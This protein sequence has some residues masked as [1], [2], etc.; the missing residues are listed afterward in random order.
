MQDNTVMHEKR[1]IQTWIFWYFFIFLKYIHSTAGK[2]NIQS[3]VCCLISYFY[4]LFLCIIFKSILWRQS[5][6]LY[7]RIQVIFYISYEEH[8]DP[9]PIH[10]RVA[11]AVRH[12]AVLRDAWVAS[13]VVVVYIRLDKYIRGTPP[14]KKTTTTTTMFA[15]VGLKNWW[16][17]DSDRL[18]YMT[19][20]TFDYIRIWEQF[21]FWLEKKK[22]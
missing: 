17:M 7:L 8:G 6:L 16:N 4:I 13:T 9:F 11:T 3:D 22:N 10:V 20:A 15:H 1:F 18:P 14:K 19:P 21:P 2:K 12:V 5:C